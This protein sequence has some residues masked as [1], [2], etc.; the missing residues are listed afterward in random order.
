MPVPEINE[1]VSQFAFSPM[2]AKEVKNKAGWTCEKTGRRASDGWRMEACHDNHDKNNP[3]YNN[4]VNGRCFCL[5][6]H[7]EQHVRILQTCPE[8]MR[9]W[10]DV[11]VH[12]IAKR[13]YSKGLRYEKHYYENPLDIIDDR[14]E[15]VAILMELGLDPEEYI[16]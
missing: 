12:L 10:A 2:V 9:S 4:E 3:Y 11:S 5:S 13:A 14:D 1:Q 6:A 8:Y 15:V 16:F 7:L